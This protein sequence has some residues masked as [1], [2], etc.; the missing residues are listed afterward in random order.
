MMSKAKSGKHYRLGGEHGFTL[1]ELLVVIAIISL[2]VSILLPSLS[3]A[4]DLAKRVMCMN[5]LKHLHLACTFYCMDNQDAIP[6]YSVAGD[7]TEYFMFWHRYIYPFVTKGGDP[8]TW[9]EDRHG[10][11]ICPGDETPYCDLLSYG[12]NTKLINRRFAEVKP[13]VIMIGDDQSAQLCPDDNPDSG[14]YSEQ[15][16]LESRHSEGDNFVHIDGH[17]EW[18]TGLETYEENPDLWE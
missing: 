12:M 7:P 11:Y 5:N 8:T 14:L 10:L 9:H 3:K 17:V 6:M 4:K 2:L 16:G 18:L 13:E 1:I 15:Y